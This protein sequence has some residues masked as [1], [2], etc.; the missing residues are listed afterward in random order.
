MRK[1]WAKEAKFGAGPQA[2][3]RGRKQ[4]KASFLD[5]QKR[6]CEGSRAVLG[7]RGSGGHCRKRVKARRKKHFKGK[8]K[9]IW[10]WT[11]IVTVARANTS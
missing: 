9:S 7:S 4:A 1:S 3:C 11:R 8:T 5:T 6:S 2:G 10:R